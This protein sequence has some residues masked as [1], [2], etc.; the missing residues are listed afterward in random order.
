M[1]SLQRKN[2][3]RFRG[4]VSFCGT[5]CR[6]PSCCEN[7]LYEREDFKYRHCFFARCPYDKTKITLREEPLDIP[8]V[9]EIRKGAMKP[10]ERQQLLPLSIRRAERQKP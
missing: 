8:D 7:C 3:N 1:R 6:K 2:L 9:I 5:R 4:E 10:W